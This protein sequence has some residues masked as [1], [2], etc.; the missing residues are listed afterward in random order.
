MGPLGRPELIVLLVVLSFGWLSLGASNYWVGHLSTIF[1]G[2]GQLSNKFSSNVTSRITGNSTHLLVVELRILLTGALFVMAG[3][4]FV[5]RCADSRAIEALAGAPIL[6]VAAQSY[7]GEGLLRVELYGLPFTSLLAASALLPSTRGEIRSLVPP[8]PVGRVSRIVAAIVPSVIAV[9][10]LC[11]ALATTVVRGGNDEYESFSSGELAAV[12]YVYNH[13]RQ[14]QVIGVTN[15]FLP[16]GQRKIDAVN[17]FIAGGSGSSDVPALAQSL[18]KAR[19]NY[20]ILS[21]SEEAYGV[22]V[23]GFKPGW[24]VVIE[25]LLVEHGYEV[26]VHWRTAIVLKATNSTS[27][28]GSNAIAK[29]WT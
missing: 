22:Q 5:R 7:G 3:V 8:I 10:L 21:K 1:G 4:G 29:L 15:Y 25:R 19:P 26:V 24:E 27:G 23:E 6:L 13:I 17:E 14:G 2:G 28:S 11:S 12:N 18:V 9:A 16:I 20:V